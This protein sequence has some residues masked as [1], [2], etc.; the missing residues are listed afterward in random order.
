M[1]ML[2]M[3]MM[4]MILPAVFLRPLRMNVNSNGIDAMA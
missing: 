1:M 4:P 3:R 2:M